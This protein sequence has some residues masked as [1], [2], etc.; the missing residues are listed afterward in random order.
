MEYSVF[1]SALKLISLCILQNMNHFDQD[2]RNVRPIVYHGFSY[3]VS[4]T[5]C[6][7][8]SQL[9]RAVLSQPGQV[10]SLSQGHI[11]K[12]NK[13][14]FTVTLRDNLAQCVF[15]LWQEARRKSHLTD[16]L[17]FTKW[18]FHHNTFSLSAPDPGQPAG[19]LQGLRG[20]L[21]GCAGD[22]RKV[23]P[24]QHP[25]PEDLRG[26]SGPRCS[27][28]IHHI[29]N[30]LHFI[31]ELFF[32]S[33][34]KICS[35]FYFKRKILLK[36]CQLWPHDES[37]KHHSSLCSEVRTAETLMRRTSKKNSCFFQAHSHAVNQSA[38]IIMMS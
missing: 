25:V 12:K 4:H 37:L 34:S 21:Q 8:L 19:R 6:R 22:G 28:I 9:F 17:F 18:H 2:C 10:V 5:W 38:I 14:T 30:K 33:H 31:W 36:Q 32:L 27:C 7:S 20:Q 23:Q 29:H 35:Q 1:P 16:Y 11:E 15:G 24:R 13:K 3:T 26:T